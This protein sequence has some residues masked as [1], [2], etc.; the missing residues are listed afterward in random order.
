MV[1]AMVMVMVM[2]MVMPMVMVMVFVIVIANA[3]TITFTH[4]VPHLFE[5]LNTGVFTFFSRVIQRCL[6]ILHRRG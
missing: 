3:P 1:M 4:A 2:V 6:T 5:Q